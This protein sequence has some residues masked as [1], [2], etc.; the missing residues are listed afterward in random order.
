MRR[1]TV[2]SETL[3]LDSF[4]KRSARRAIQRA[5]V[6]V[7]REKPIRQHLR[8]AALATHW[9]VEDWALEWTVQFDHGR[10]EFHR[11]KVGRPRITY[12]W[13]TAA[14]FLEQVQ[15]G[16]NELAQPEVVADLPDR[17]FCE[18]VFAA[19]VKSLRAV[20]A[21]PIDDDGERIW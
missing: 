10:L 1:P 16:V 20:L 8:E 9:I 18:P 19:F 12:L 2:Q 11:G 7:G 21:N 13:H 6:L 3:T 14:D 5:F 17:R 15:S 4:S